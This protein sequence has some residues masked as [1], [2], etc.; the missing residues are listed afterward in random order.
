MPPER[1]RIGASDTLK[2]RPAV[3]PEQTCIPALIWSIAIGPNDDEFDFFVF[4]GRL[5]GPRYRHRATAMNAVFAV[6]SVVI[7]EMYRRKDFYVLLILT[8]VITLSMASVNFFGDDKIIRIIKSLC[9]QMIWISSLVIAISTIAR[10]VPSEKESRTIY[11]LLAKPISRS[12][13]LAGKFLGCW[14]ACGIALVCF[15]LFFGFVSA[16]REHRWPLLAYFQAGTMH[17]ALLGIVIGMVLLGSLVFAAP[18]SN[19]TIC[20]VLI[21]GF[22]F[23]AGH[24]NLVALGTAQPERGVI[25]GI[26]Y[27]IPH[28]EWFYNVS[29]RILHDWPPVDWS[30]YGIALGYAACYSALFLAAACLVFRR[31]ALN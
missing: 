17:W 10:Q 26:Y 29:E 13:L 30:A 24:L 6:A 18:S 12:Q 11:P 28:L 9:L 7:K 27:V 3:A 19:G 8:A 5:L 15:Y 1:S 31:K 2:I 14:L 22:L 16:S 25:Y 23:L 4:A 20:A 21:V